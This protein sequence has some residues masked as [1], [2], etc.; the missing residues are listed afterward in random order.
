MANCSVLWVLKET[1]LMKVGTFQLWHSIRATR[2]LISS[3]AQYVR[4][5]SKQIKQKLINTF[6]QLFPA[7]NAY[8]SSRWDNICNWFY[9]YFLSI[10]LLSNRILVC[11]LS[12]IN[13]RLTCL[14]GSGSNPHL[15]NLWPL[16][17]R[18]FNLS[19]GWQKWLGTNSRFS[20]PM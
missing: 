8:C 18:A 16:A 19:T 1:F 9:A 14:T 2:R 7:M 15:G 6:R 11:I 20:G 3:V 12:S 13:Y 4:L 17:N 10:H 5:P